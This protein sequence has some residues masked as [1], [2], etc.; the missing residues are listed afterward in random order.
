[1][2]VAGLPFAGE[3][4]TPTMFIRAAAR[5]GLSARAVR[6]RLTAI[7]KLVLPAVLIL[8]GGRS[9]VLLDFPRRNVA[10]IM[11][12]ESGGG[13]EDADLKTLI[14]DYSGYAIFVRPEF[15]FDAHDEPA[16]APRPTAWFWG[17]LGESWWSYVQ[18]ALA[19]VVIN[20]FALASPLFIMTV[21]DRVVPNN[22]IET[23][24]VLAAGAG[25]VFL[26]DFIL[27][28]LR[29]YFIDTAGK[30]A[31]VLLASRI[32]EQVLDMQMAARPGSAGAFANTLREFEALRDFFTSAT[33]AAVI[34]LPFVLFYV[35][36][37]WLIGGQI[38]QV[39]MVAVPLVL[40]VGL[41]LQWPLGH[42]VQRNMH[43]S[44]LK[45]GVL[46]E[47]LNG[48]ETLKSLGGEPGMRQKWEAFVGLT[49]QSGL[50]A[51]VISQGG[52]HFATLVSQLASVAVVIYGV[53]LI[54]DG[55]MTVGGLIACVILSGRALAP[56]VQIAQLLTR[57][58]RSMASLQA[59]NRIMQAPTERPASK[60]FLHRPDLTGGVTFQDL[61]FT[62]PGQDLEVLKGVNF[63][64]KPG[65]RVGLIG[66]V[67]SGKSTVAK[68]ILGLYEP[69]AGAILIDGTDIRQIDPADLRRSV[70]YVPQDVFLFRGSVR[71]NITVSAP[72][73]D[74]VAVLRAATLA[75]VDDFVSQHPLGYDLPVGERG[76]NLS[77]GQRQAIAIARA[78]IHEPSLLIFDEPTSAMDTRGEEALKTRI[79]GI[80]SSRTL[81]LITHRASL[82]TLVDRLIVFDHGRIAADGPRKAVI[83]ALASGKL[84][85]AKG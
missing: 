12:P 69:T 71:D 6:R 13:V 78:L 14:A 54:Q 75:G 23:L 5:A 40:L 72:Q 74:D 84:M 26:F 39:H 48:L 22:A 83:D 80:L 25:T 81:V 43:E 8:E 10:K 41:A 32:F 58:N 1:V 62:Y 33:L 85:S 21:Y 15:T 65:E 49:A 45:H 76:E 68:L 11:L 66:R 77:G 7:P 50:A 17:T 70:A 38:A 63:A 3:R 37:I 82:L 9:C 28:Q 34:D 27:K 56:L 46:V 19:A 53:F 52:V 16:V 18:V 55:I 47:S 31:D 67:G 4:L 44:E 2:L 29:G 73:A 35:A 59:L 36:V 51:R 24:W 60:V 30:R 20:M 61:R 64:I 79:G 57:F 42:V